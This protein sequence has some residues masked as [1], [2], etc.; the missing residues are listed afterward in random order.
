MIKKNHCTKALVL[1]GALM[2]SSAFATL[3][4]FDADNNERAGDPLTFGSSS[5]LSVWGAANHGLLPKIEGGAVAYLDAGSFSGIGVCKEP[6]GACAG[7]PDDNMTGAEYLLFEHTTDIFTSMTLNGNH[8]AYQ[9]GHI[10][11]DANGLTGGINLMPVTVT[12]GIVDLALLGV[13]SSFLV[14]T[15]GNMIAPLTI[16]PQGRDGC[17]PPPAIQAYVGSVST[18]P[19]PAAAWLFGSALMGLA[20]VARKRKLS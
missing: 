2:S 6:G 11:I 20:G 10:F 9:A 5:E 19:I 3:Y 14:S 15:A 17:H 7:N 8:T 13:G 12:G 4:D 18:V 16:C 1:A